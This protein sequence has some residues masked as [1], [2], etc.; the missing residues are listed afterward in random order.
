MEHALTRTAAENDPDFLTR[1]A[2][3]WADAI[4]QDGTE[5]TEEELRHRQGAF[6]RRPR[7]GLHHLEIFATPDQYEH[8]LTV[9]NTA[10]NPRTHPDN[11]S[12]AGGHREH[13]GQ[14]GADGAGWRRAGHRRGT[15]DALMPTWTAAPGPSNSSTASSAPAKQPSPP[16]PCPPPEDSAPRSWSPSTTRTS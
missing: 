6:L 5:P 10:T 4:D 14:H 2:R 1:I 7:R 8:L 3:R 11:G 15:G 12:G 16:E 13:A 9:M